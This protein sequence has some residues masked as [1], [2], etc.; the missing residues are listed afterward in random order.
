MLNKVFLLVIFSY[1]VFFVFY[2]IEVWVGEEERFFDKVRIFFRIW[3]KVLYFN[4]KF[5]EIYLYINVVRWYCNGYC[6]ILN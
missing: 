1:V 6:I 3:L 5:I 4:L 2:C